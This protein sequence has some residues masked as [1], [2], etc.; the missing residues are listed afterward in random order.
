[1]SRKRKNLWRDKKGAAVVEAAMLLPVMM[2][3]LFGLWDLGNGIL[4]NQHT[5]TASQVVGDLITREKEVSTTTL[6]NYIAAGRLA[7]GNNDTQSYGIDIVSIAFEEN[8]VPKVL[9]RETRNMAPNGDV[10]DKV[11]GL[12][13]EGEGVVAVTVSYTYRPMFS[14]M[15][16]SQMVME[17]EAYLR[18]RRSNT[19]KRI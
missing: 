17:E 6:N 3:M 19:V 14:S 13:N 12:G 2:V 8:G 10:L 7:Y 9:W 18:G 16:M 11:R 5:I 4:Y 1:M 15:F